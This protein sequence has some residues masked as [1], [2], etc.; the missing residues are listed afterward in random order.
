MP[1]TKSTDH[2]LYNLIAMLRPWFTDAG[3]KIAPN[4]QVHYG[5]PR[6]RHAD[7]Q[8]TYGA[9][10]CGDSGLDWKAGQP[11]SVA[12]IPYLD[13]PKEVGH[14]VIHE[15]VHSAL[16]RGSKHGKL[17][18]AACT[19]IGLVMVSSNGRTEIDDGLH[20]HRKK[21]PGSEKGRALA[22]HLQKLTQHLGP[23]PA[24]AIPRPPPPEPRNHVTTKLLCPACRITV[25]AGPSTMEKVRGGPRIGCIKPD[26]E[27]CGEPLM[28]PEEAHEWRTLSAEEPSL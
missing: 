26:C 5:H 14:V 3:Y 19:A 12:V 1:K 11:H 22:A 9:D 24:T 13:D 6:S 17:F 23:F 4:L 2:W 8:I 21:F 10:S 15:C 25:R 27:R 16:P 28:T 7:G 18:Q 20:T